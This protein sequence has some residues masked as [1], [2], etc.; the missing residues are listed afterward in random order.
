MAFRLRPLSVN[1]GG[2]REMNVSL[3][4]ATAVS[5]GRRFA[6]CSAAIVPV[7]GRHGHPSDEV[8]K[9]CDASG[10]RM[11]RNSLNGSGAE[12]LN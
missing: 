8:G 7:D 5:L 3:E 1:V 2:R 9:Q 6:A 12:N 4:N 10:S 11:H